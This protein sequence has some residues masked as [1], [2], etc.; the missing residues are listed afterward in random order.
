MLR[1]CK[2]PRIVEL[3]GV[4]LAVRVGRRGVGGVRY[5]RGAAWH[6]RQCAR[7]ASCTASEA[8]TRCRRACMAL[9][10]SGSLSRLAASTLACTGDPS[11]PQPT[12]CNMPASMM[13]CHL[14]CLAPL[15]P[16]TGLAAG[17]CN[18]V[19]ARRQPADATAGA[20]TVPCAAL[21]GKVRHEA[22]QRA[23]VAWLSWATEC[24]QESLFMPNRASVQLA[25]GQ[26]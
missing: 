13:C 10:R 15:P 22:V 18:E 14:P 21:G 9:R 3:R 6:D 16:P 11:L 5:T 24:W 1:A 19:H 25:S 26:L 2:H 12:W 23:S 8:R 7:E 17:G 20:E 4:A